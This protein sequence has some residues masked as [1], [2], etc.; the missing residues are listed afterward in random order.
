ML[1][2]A[3]FFCA[4]GFYLW[5]RITKTLDIGLFLVNTPKFLPA[6]KTL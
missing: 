2:Y 3:F 1:A 5:I 6:F 4:F